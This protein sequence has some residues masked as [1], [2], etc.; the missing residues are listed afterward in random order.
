MN[1]ADDQSI[2]WYAKAAERL[3]TSDKGKYKSFQSKDSQTHE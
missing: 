2:F 3:M 1:V